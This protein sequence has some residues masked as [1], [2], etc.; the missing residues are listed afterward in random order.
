MG[1]L[2]AVAGI[3][4]HTEGGA[5][6]VISAL[7]GLACV[8]AVAVKQIN[9][10]VTAA[11]LCGTDQTVGKIVVIWHGRV[12]GA[13]RVNELVSDQVKEFE[14]AKV[15]CNVFVDGDG[16]AYSSVQWPDE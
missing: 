7:Y 2:N 10:K 13:D 9:G 12:L 8:S 5:A 3:N 15:A 16:I 6:H 1:A 11:A 4:A 14:N